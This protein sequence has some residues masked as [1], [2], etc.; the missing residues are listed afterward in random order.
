MKDS[1]IMNVKVNKL[2]V[3]IKV[4]VQRAFRKFQKI[5]INLKDFK[6]VTAVI[7]NFKIKK[8]KHPNL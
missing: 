7:K 1:Q 3:K 2:N 6:E 8:R 4:Y 5:I